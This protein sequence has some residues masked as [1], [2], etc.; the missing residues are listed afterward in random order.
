MRPPGPYLSRMNDTT[1]TTNPVSAGKL[2]FGLVLL[3]V[4]VL[5][6]ADSIDLWDFRDLWRYWPVALIALGVAK[7]IDVLRTRRG[8]NGFV[9]IAVGVWMLA[10]TQRFLGLDYGSAFPLGVVVAGLG[11]I[12][13]ALVG[14]ENKKENHS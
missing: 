6:F 1:T 11:I 5:A 10:A 7:E 4:G 3:G 9:L 14:V 2:V 13:H 8:D 12:L